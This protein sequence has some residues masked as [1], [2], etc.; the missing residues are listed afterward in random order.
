MTCTHAPCHVLPSFIHNTQRLKRMKMSRNSKRAFNGIS[1]SHVAM[2]D[3][4]GFTMPP[5]KAVTPDSATQFSGMQEYNTEL[6]ATL[7]VVWQRETT[8][9]CTLG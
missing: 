1:W 5:E 7:S 8:A 9:S 6:P 2:Q 4:R 3:G